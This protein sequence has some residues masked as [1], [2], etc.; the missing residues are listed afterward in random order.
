MDCVLVH[1]LETKLMWKPSAWG[2]KII[3][4]LPSVSIDGYSRSKELS[5]SAAHVF[6]VYCSQKCHM[7]SLKFISSGESKDCH[8]MILYIFEDVRE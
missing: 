6:F 1:S 4:V 7:L 2:R 3:I 8:K 5:L